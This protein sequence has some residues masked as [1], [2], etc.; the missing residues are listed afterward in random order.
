MGVSSSQPIKF[1]RE[2]K[3]LFRQPA[4]VM[5]GERQRHLV[6]A[7]INVGGATPLARSAMAFTI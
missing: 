3:I 1:F 2:P 4:F 7:D 6:P 5:S